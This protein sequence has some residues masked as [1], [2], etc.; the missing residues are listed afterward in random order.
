MDLNNWIMDKMIMQQLRRLEQA[1]AEKVELEG[2]ERMRAEL[3]LVKQALAELRSV[4]L[5]RDFEHVGAEVYFFKEVKPRFHSLLI[6][7]TERYHYEVGCPMLGGKELERYGKRQL[8]FIGQ[9]FAQHK[10]MYEYYRLGASDLDERLFVR[11]N[12]SDD[13]SFVGLPE[14]YP[15]FSTYGEYLF[16][17]FMALEKLALSIRQQLLGLDGMAAAEMGKMG[18]K[19]LKWTGESINL[20]EIAYGLYYT[21][22]LNEGRANIIDIVKV[23]EEVFGVNLGRPYRRLAEIRQRKRLSRTKFIEEM[24][25]AIG[26]KLDEEDE[27]RP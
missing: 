12:V 6:L 23:L 2:L 20:L 16:S 14:I 26:R 18:T 21:G 22:Q 9:F 10:L 27:Y 19:K 13:F 7:A 15:V 3:A 8:D 4:V 17:K 5:E 11:A 25:L 24:G 1:L